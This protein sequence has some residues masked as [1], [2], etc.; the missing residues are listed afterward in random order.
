MAD[1][2]ETTPAPGPV[3]LVTDAD[4]L[5][6]ISARFQDAAVRGADLAFDQA[7]GRFALM[8]NRYMHERRPGFWGRTFGAPGL[9]CRA[10]LH[11]N[12]VLKVDA[13]AM[14]D[15]RD[16]DTVLSLLAIRFEPLDQEASA[17]GAHDGTDG[18]EDA[19]SVALGGHV[20][21][22]FSGGAAIRLQVECLEAEARD[23]GLP[24]RAG[25]RPRHPN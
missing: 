23:L 1:T 5:T 21:M 6:V 12:H 18:E 16:V 19:P 4:D 7:H 10:A 14:P 3:L 9:R 15:R 22:S 17:R 20:L 11:F 25:N 24:W 13:Q 2:S 8:A